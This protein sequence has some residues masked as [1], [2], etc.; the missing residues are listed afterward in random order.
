MLESIS[1]DY[2]L[3]WQML[4]IKANLVEKSASLLAKKDEAEDNPRFD[5]PSPRMN[6][7]ARFHQRAF[8][9]FNIVDLAD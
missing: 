1:A 4:K 3:R 2:C 6:K 7:K 9:I 5:S 8:F